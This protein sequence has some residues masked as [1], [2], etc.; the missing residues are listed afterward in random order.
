MSFRNSSAGVSRG[1]GAM[2]V[3]ASRYGSVKV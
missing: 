3:L 2:G 1:S